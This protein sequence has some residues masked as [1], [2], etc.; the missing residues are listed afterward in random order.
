MVWLTWKYVEEEENTPVL[1]HT[2]EVIEAYVTTEAR[3]KLYKYLDLLKEMAMYCDTDSV[4]YIQKCG[5]PPAV[6]CGDKLGDMMNELD[7]D[8]Y[9]KEFMLGWPKNYA[10]KI[11][12][13]A[14]WNRRLCK[15]RGITLNYSAAN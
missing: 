9:I 5:E 11:I 8:G 10:Y 12:T 13:P 1:R 15:V 14:L 3:L 2:N 6:T 4:I 7:R